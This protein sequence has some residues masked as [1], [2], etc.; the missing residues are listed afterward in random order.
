MRV[1]LMQK[2]REH[3]ATPLLA[4]SF[5]ANLL[6]GDFGLFAMTATLASLAVG[7]LTLRAWRKF[8]Q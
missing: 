6:G 5:A 1:S 3:K 8:V 4:D 2:N 7:L